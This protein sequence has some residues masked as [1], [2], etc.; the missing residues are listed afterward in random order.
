MEH[1]D[2]LI[3]SAKEP[4]EIVRRK[5]NQGE[6]L[7]KES[8]NSVT[9]EEAFK[10]ISYV[11]YVMEQAYSGYTYFEKALFDGAFA[12]MEQDLRSHAKDIHVTD[13]IDIISNR[14]SFI[15]DGHLSLTTKEY[16]KGFYKKTQTYIADI[17]LDEIDGKYIDVSQ[18]KRV[19]LGCDLSLFPTISLGDNRTF[20][21]GKR[22]KE[23]IE[24]IELK[25]E[26][27]TEKF[28]VHKI[29]SKEI[30]AEVLIQEEYDEEIAY[31]TCSSFVGDSR[32]DYKK[33]RKIG[34]RC[35]KY[36]NVIWDLS[37]NLGGNSEFPK[38]FLLGLNGSCIDTSNILE[39]RSSLVHAKEYGE[40]KEVPYHFEHCAIK[41]TAKH[42]LFAGTLHVI[43]NDRVASSAENAITMA[44]SMKNVI[45]YGC[46]SMGIGR[47]GDLCA[48][49]L[50]NSKMILWCPQKVFESSSEETMGYEPDIWVDSSDVISIVKRKIQANDKS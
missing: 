5:F 3:Y 38:Q 12:A 30:G 17:Q 18:G 1:T 39:L 43:I 9:F 41:E 10:D 48:Y 26:V 16:A 37:N 44:A 22:S 50:P 13:M 23:L 47:F 46:N 49:Y 45:F 34:E 35:R 15:N 28:P 11:Q 7:Y 24:Q 27:E 36:K 33:I 19:Y 6:N 31:I 14:L 32:D 4:M 40:L 29:K 20:L 2:F 25:V 42:D 8:P 21:V